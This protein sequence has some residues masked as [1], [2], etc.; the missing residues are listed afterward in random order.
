MLNL[1][2]DLNQAHFHLTGWVP[3]KIVLDPDDAV[4]FNW[5]CHQDDFWTNFWDLT[6]WG[7]TGFRGIPVL[8]LE[9]LP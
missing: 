8:A 7:H 3:L 9:K 2:K 6:G 1:L 5:G 4:I